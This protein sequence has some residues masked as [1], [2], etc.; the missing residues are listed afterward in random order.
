LVEKSLK[1]LKGTKVYIKLAIGSIGN[2]WKINV[3]IAIKPGALVVGAM[4]DY[5]EEP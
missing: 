1:A 4:N 5:I 2:N 3:D